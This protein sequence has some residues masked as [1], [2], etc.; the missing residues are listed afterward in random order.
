[1]NESIRNKIVAL[2]GAA[3]ELNRHVDCPVVHHFAPGM[4]AR[5][6]FIPKG[7]C[8]IG[9]LHRHAHVNTISHGRVHVTS[10]FGQGIIQAPYT[11][12]S[13]PGTQRVIVALEDTLWTTY[14]PNPTD[15]RDLTSIEQE[16]IAES[17]AALESTQEE[18][19]LGC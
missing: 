6:M 17:P 13:E 18:T 16:V 1:M 15:T 14:H 3:F 12:T 19:C 8:L 11:F 10:E 7:T 2:A 5:E 9:K 4:Y